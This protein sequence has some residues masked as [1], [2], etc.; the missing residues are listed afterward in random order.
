MAIIALPIMSI[1][2]LMSQIF[3]ICLCFDSNYKLPNIAYM[4][5]ARLA[6]NR[7]YISEFGKI[8]QCKLER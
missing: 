6:Y 3:I 8:A 7:F 1:Y 5:T 4:L 2:V